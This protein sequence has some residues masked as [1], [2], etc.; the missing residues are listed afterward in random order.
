[1]ICVVTGAASGIGAAVRAELEGQGREVLGVDLHD[2]EVQ[3]DLSSA[4]G[5]AEA[6]EK[7]LAAVQAGEGVDRLVLCAGVGTHCSDPGRIA[8]INYFGSVVL[9][10]ALLPSMAHRRG[11]AAVVVSSNAA[12]LADFNNDPYVQAMLDNDEPRALKL[13]RDSNA[14]LAYAGSKHALALALRLRAASFAEAGVRLNAVAPGA[15]ETPLLQG[16]RDHKVWGA[17]L[18]SV[19][20]PLGRPAQPAEIADAISF[21]LSPQAAQVHGS[22]LYVDGGS[23]AVVRPKG[24]F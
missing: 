12:Q 13:A 22:I 24:G 4:E 21:L 3:A 17:A 6:L 20:I 10:D 18:D 9:L 15:T 7:I 2:A 14:F 8:A 1:M 11:A 19:P 5:R 16:V 23:D